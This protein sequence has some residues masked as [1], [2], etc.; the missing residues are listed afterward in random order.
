MIVINSTESY[1]MEQDKENSGFEENTAE[2]KACINQLKMLL[3]I[4]E[5][6]E[7]SLLIKK[8]IEHICFL[9]N[10]LTNCDTFMKKNLNK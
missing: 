3:G 5:A 6:I 10:M 4:P 8:S 7:E 9:E 1:L 2:Y